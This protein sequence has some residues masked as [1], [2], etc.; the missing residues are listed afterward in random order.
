MD[1]INNDVDVNDLL[2]YL[3]G[4]SLDPDYQYRSMKRTLQS[5]WRREKPKMQDINYQAKEYREFTKTDSYRLTNIARNLI[6]DK[7]ETSSDHL[8]D[9]LKNQYNFT[10]N[11]VN[12]TL[13]NLANCKDVN[14]RK[15]LFKDS[16]K[17]VKSK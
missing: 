4:G 14:M 13:K 7:Y 10:T 1:N 2:D 5:D 17:I 15:E 6:S 8:T 3:S 11:E 16:V 9:V 12:E